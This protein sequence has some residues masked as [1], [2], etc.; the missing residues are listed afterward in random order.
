MKDLSVTALCM[1]YMPEKERK[2]KKG[3]I[4]FY[5]AIT[6]YL[7]RFLTLPYLTPEP[8]KNRFGLHIN[9]LFIKT[10]IQEH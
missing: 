2:G 9:S 3:N 6:F 10:V 8:Q 4:P 5:T 1:C 7:T